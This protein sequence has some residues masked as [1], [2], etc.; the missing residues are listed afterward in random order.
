MELTS[1]T[2]AILTVGIFVVAVLYSCVG[3]AGASGY[4]AVMSLMAISP[5][6]IKP[7]SLVLSIVVASLGTY[8]FSTAGHFSWRLFWPFAV[9]AVPMAF[10]G[11]YVSLPA[12]PFNITVGLVLLYSAVMFIERNPKE[13]VRG[14]PP[15]PI[16][17]AIGGALGLL[18]GLTGT[19]GG[20]FLTP[21]LLFCGWATTKKAAGVS[22]LFILV[23]SFAG[24]MGNLSSTRHVPAF[25]LILVV[26]AGIGGLIG[27]YLGS[28]RFQPIV[29]TR[30]LATVLIL[31]GTKLILT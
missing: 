15:I 21:L 24:L 23:N 26:A 11:G 14:D 27:S 19:G 8:Q 12:R 22:S 2:L 18:S 6:V 10:V 31:A 29:I 28:R 16:A 5:T 25:A 7:M 4:I 3:Q 9:L 13:S 17:I 20:L 1:D 30:V